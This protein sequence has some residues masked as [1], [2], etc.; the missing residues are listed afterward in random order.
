MSLSAAHLQM[1]TPLATPM[2][3]DPHAN[4]QAQDFPFPASAVRRP[5][6]G[7]RGGSCV[8]LGLDLSTQVGSSVRATVHERANA[9]SEALKA[10]FTDERVKVVA[11][12]SVRFDED[13]PHF[14]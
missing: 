13:L 14:G 11:E 12:Y 9:F 1:A 8:F 6:L 4:E 7:V 10:S 3:W 2:A 5:E